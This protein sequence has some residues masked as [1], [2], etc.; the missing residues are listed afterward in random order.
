MS[1]TTTSQIATGTAWARSPAAKIAGVLGLFAAML[2]PQFL[3]SGLI[4]EREDRQADVLATFRNGWGPEQV[5]TG[6]AL[7]VPYMY[8]GSGGKGVL[9]L[10]AFHLDVTATLD[11]QRR[12]R[13]LFQATIYSAAVEMSGVVTPP[14]LPD[15]GDPQFDWP[16]ARVVIAASD[17]RGM[18]PDRTMQWGDATLTLEPSSMDGCEG[19][20]LAIPAG[21][22][23]PP[24]AGTA[25]PFKLAL[26]LRGTQAFRIAPAA[27]QTTMRVTSVWPT[28]GAI[29]TS[30]PVSY[31]TGASGFDARWDIAGTPSQAGWHIQSGCEASRDA[32]T[33]PGVELQ[34]A[35]PT[36][37]MVDRAA[38]Y[39]LFFLALAY[40][41]LFLFETLSRVRIHLVQYGLVGL[42]VSLFALLLISIAEPLGFAAAYSI[43]ATAVVLQAS[44]YTLSVVRR[45]RL[46]GIFAAV[47]GALFA[48]IYVVLSLDSYA[49]LAG[50]VALFAILSVLMAVTRHINWGASAV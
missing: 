42:S 21:L 48:F 13:G 44:L 10:P 32:D 11:P 4:H 50:T 15:I 25:I 26:T 33:A 41:T 27:R 1:D 7:L 14:P 24:V 30:L 45:A 22:K 28:P 47:L 18:P 35:V 9:R 38:K 5:V 37:A 8:Q 43:S 29:G 34:E 2:I 23:G 49:L 20:S 16:A 39:G 40:L 3:T 12:R 46:A 36:Y 6:P 19:G 17:L 31:Q